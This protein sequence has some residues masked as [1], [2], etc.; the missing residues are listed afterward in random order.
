MNSYFCDYISKNI[1]DKKGLESETCFLSIFVQNLKV[2][3]KPLFSR[4]VNTTIII[5]I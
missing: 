4:A 1:Q 5:M 3:N 2:L